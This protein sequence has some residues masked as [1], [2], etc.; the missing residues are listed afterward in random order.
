[1]KVVAALQEVRRFRVA[2]R[3][4]TT[5]FGY[6]EHA[7]AA[8]YK[9]WFRTWP[10]TLFGGEGVASAE[11]VSRYGVYV[12]AMPDGDIVYIGKATPRVR[13]SEAIRGD[14]R[15]HLGAEIC[16]KFKTPRMADG[17]PIFESGSLAGKPKLSLKVREA[18]RLGNILVTA[19]EIEPFAMAAC[20]EAYLQAAVFLKDGCLP[21]ANDR[22]G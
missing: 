11:V 9:D 12:F 5:A 19:I 13:S 6:R 17:V 10:T 4:A 14:S 22:I 21:P 18:L 7:P 3:G 20:V 1:M 2:L 8:P 15:Y 16:A